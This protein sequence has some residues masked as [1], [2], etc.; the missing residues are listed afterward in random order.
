MV[1]DGD[2]AGQSSTNIS[3]PYSTWLQGQ[4]L[5]LELV[6]VTLRSE[7]RAVKSQLLL[8]VYQQ[9]MPAFEECC[10]LLTLLSHPFIWLS[11]LNK[12]IMPVMT[13]LQGQSWQNHIESPACHRYPWPPHC[14]VIKAFSESSRLPSISGLLLLVAMALRFSVCREDLSD[15]LLLMWLDA[16]FPRTVYMLPLFPG[17][18]KRKKEVK[19]QVHGYLDRGNILQQGVSLV[20]ESLFIGN[21]PAPSIKEPNP[22]RLNC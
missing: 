3:F 13:G 6:T 17:G 7:L 14:D 18:G 21:I 1:A 2:F 12:V 22:S 10:L 5:H 20:L 19:F 4:V 16:S 15:A 8:L 11:T 9:N